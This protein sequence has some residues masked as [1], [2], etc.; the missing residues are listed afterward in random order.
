MEMIVLWMAVEWDNR[1]T[2]LRGWWS[3][4]FTDALMWHERPDDGGAK[5]CTQGISTAQAS[6][7]FTLK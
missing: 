4:Q 2:A 5:E 1:V 7:V 6:A 3:V